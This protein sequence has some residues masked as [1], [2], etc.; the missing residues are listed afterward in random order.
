MTLKQLL[1][2]HKPAILG[3][4]VNL[5]LETYAP[6]TASFL[7][8]EGDRF[9]NPIGHATAQ[10]LGKILDEL[11]GDSGRG[12]TPCYVEDIVKI[13][14]VQDF[15]AAQAI[16][17]AWLLK[18]AVTDQIGGQLSDLHLAEWFELE[19]KIDGLAA[20]SMDIYA[21]CRER[22]Y[23]IKARELKAANEI[24]F[25]MQGRNHGDAGKQATS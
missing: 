22:I 17:F 13:R 20:M 2:K 21:A 3:R 5:V 11:V 14:A 24:A 8:S 4:W 7:K 18:K 6:N 25:R 1:N 9:A 19:A 23:Q 12:I 16:S 10:G 15:S